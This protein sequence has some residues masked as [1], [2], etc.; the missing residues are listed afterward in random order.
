MPTRRL[1]AELAAR[2]AATAARSTWARIWR[3]SIRKARAGR[4]QLHVVGGALQ[5]Q[6]AQLPFQPLQLLA[7]RGLDDVLACGGPAEVQLLGQGD[8]VAQLAKLHARR[9]LIGICHASHATTVWRCN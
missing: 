9:P 2:C 6:Y 3:A 5:Q 4:G 7:Q 8:E 1:G